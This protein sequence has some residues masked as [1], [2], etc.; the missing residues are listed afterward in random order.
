MGF[1][2][3]MIRVISKRRFNKLSA[4]NAGI[5]FGPILIKPK[6]GTVDANK[7]ILKDIVKII[8]KE[9]DVIFRDKKHKG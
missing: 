8:I 7:A 4:T 5:I 1:V 3:S 9:Y 2:Y 6:S